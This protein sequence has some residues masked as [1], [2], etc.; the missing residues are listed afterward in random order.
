MENKKYMILSA[1]MAV[2]LVAV[3]LFVAFMLTHVR[4]IELKENDYAALDL[5]QVEDGSYYGEEAA[6]LIKVKL[7]VT[8]KN[9]TISEI[10]INSHR[11]A[12]GK[13]AEAIIFDIIEENSLAVDAISGATSSSEVIKAAVYNALN[14]PAEKE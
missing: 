7:E 11:Q 9:N 4:T 3:L 1:A 13:A 8:V 14:S 2:F 10:T 6:G 12:K 5:A